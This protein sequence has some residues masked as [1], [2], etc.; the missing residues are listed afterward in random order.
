MPLLFSPCTASSLLERGREG[1][2]RREEAEPGRRMCWGSS[3]VE[4]ARQGL[5]LLYTFAGRG[6]GEVHFF[7]PNFFCVFL[8]EVPEMHL[9]SQGQPSTKGVT[10]QMTSPGFL[11][12]DFGLAGVEV[13]L[14]PVKW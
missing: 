13:P 1:D 11:H 14:L 6:W 2:S 4:K 8:N 12:L 3:G 10:H 9:R 7:C 5:C